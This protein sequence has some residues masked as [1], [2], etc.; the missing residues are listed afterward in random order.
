MSDLPFPYSSVL[1]EHGQAIAVI[2]PNQRSAQDA[3][4]YGAMADRMV[5]LAQKQ[6]GFLGLESVR[7]QEGRGIT[8]SYWKDRPAAL[9]WKAVGEHARAQSMGREKWYDTYVVRIARIQEEYGPGLP[10]IFHE[11][12]RNSSNDAGN[13]GSCPDLPVLARYNAWAN[14]RLLKASGEL[15]EMHHEVEIG[16]KSVLGLWKHS[17]ETDAMWLSRFTDGKIAA[18][19]ISDARDF[20]RLREMR[21]SLDQDIIELFSTLAGMEQA[22]GHGTDAAAKKSDSL[23]YES[24]IDGKRRTL[25]LALLYFHFFNHQTYHRGQLTVVLRQLG[26]KSE[27]TDIV[28]MLDP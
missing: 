15:H 22:S 6:P 21:T 19:V 13:S 25:S 1:Q 16:C 20:H 18:K 3:E 11:S 23:T 5:E 2:F 9:A 4:G 7:D 28:W 14:Q 10:A 26:I 8:I 27:M 17:I 24:Q 12:A